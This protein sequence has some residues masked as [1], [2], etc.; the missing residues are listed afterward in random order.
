MPSH[1]Y[2]DTLTVFASPLPKPSAFPTFLILGA[3]RGLHPQKLL[4][5][6]FPSQLLKA[7]GKGLVRRLQERIKREMIQQ[8][9]RTLTASTV[10]EILEC[11]LKGDQPVLGPQDIYQT[12]EDGFMV[13]GF[14]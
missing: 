14:S 10:A 4:E 2:S 12:Q 7:G 13:S 5:M 9:L 6:A 11:L 1:S 3:Q 8:L